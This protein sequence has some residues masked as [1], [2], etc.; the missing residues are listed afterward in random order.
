MM[1][2]KQR[3]AKRN[4]YMKIYRQRNAKKIRLYNREFMRRKRA[5]QKEAIV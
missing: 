2:P 4:R 3:R 1:T 5:K